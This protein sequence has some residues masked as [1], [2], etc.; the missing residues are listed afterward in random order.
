MVPSE[1]MSRA[2]P[3]LKLTFS[4]LADDC[5][6]G[7]SRREVMLGP[8]N[9]IPAK[10]DLDCSPGVGRGDGQGGP[11]GDITPDAGALTLCCEL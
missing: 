2:R 4:S 9:S 1:D 6:F 5:F 10:G 11:T 8:A 3:A 7:D